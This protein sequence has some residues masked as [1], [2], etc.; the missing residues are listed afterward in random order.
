MVKVKDPQ[1]SE[2][3]TGA[4]IKQS[5]LHPDCF[6]DELSLSVTELSEYMVCP[7]RFYYRYGMGLEEGIV[8]AGSAHDEPRL[9]NARKGKALL[10]GLD[11]GNAVHFVLKH[12]RLQGDLEQKGREI[13][14][15]L[16]RQGLSS[17]GKEIEDLKD[18]ILSFFKNDVGRA[19]MN[20]GK[21]AVLRELPFVMR[22][23]NQHDSFKVLIQGAVDLIYQD[24]EGVWN[25]VDYKYSSGKEI[26]RERYK[27][28]LMIYA[29]AVMKQ[30]KTDRVQLMINVLEDGGVP[31]TQWHVTRDELENFADQIL[32]CAHEIAQS[33]TGGISRVGTSPAESVCHHRDCIFL[34]RCFK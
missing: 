32:V 27:L 21:R 12:I 29:L 24:T 14:A 31:L 13:D 30:V 23:K 1:K 5:C 34:Q 15:L 17:A 11:K 8:S 6:P 18:N 22:L 2:A 7:Q 9:G 19:L 26:D 16:L 28:Q 25:I 4:I 33:Q 20:N 10:S 3:L